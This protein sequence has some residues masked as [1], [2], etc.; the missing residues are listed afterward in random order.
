MIGDGSAGSLAVEDPVVRALQAFL[1]VPTPGG[2]A[3]ISN[4][5]DWCFDALSIDEVV[6][7]VAGSAL[8]S[9]VPDAALIRNWC[10]LGSIKVVTI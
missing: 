3:E 4:F 1:L 6:T 10:A 2:T 8:S 5:V 9:G 7:F